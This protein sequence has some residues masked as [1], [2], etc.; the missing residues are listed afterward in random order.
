MTLLICVGAQIALTSLIF[1]I[2]VF[3]LG[4]IANPILSIGLDPSG[5]IFNLWHIFSPDRRQVYFPE[6]DDE[7]NSWAA[8][9]TKG[10][11]SLGLLGVIKVMITS[12]FQLWFRQAPVGG[13]GRGVTGR[14]RI[15]T[16]TWLLILIG[17]GTVIWVSFLSSLKDILTIC[18]VYG[19]WLGCGQREFLNELEK[20]SWIFMVMRMMMSHKTSIEAILSHI[21]FSIVIYV[22]MVN[23]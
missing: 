4:F 16:A 23:P 8:H 2:A 7:E 1:L 13:R 20:G 15:Q 17:A 12:P 10:F 21:K 11:A 3:V 6:I 9:F 5:H 18:R 22:R 14:D 19:P